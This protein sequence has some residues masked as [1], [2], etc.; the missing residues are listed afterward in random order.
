MNDGKMITGNEVKTAVKDEE[1]WRGEG[2]VWLTICILFRRYQG[3]W[4]NPV[5]LNPLGRALLSEAEQKAI[6]RHPVRAFHQSPFIFIQGL[7]YW[8]RWERKREREK[9]QVDLDSPFIWYLWAVKFF[10]AAKIAH[11]GHLDTADPV[12]IWLFMGQYVQKLDS[13][14]RLI[15]AQTNY[16]RWAKPFKSSGGNTK[17]ICILSSLTCLLISLPWLNWGNH[18]AVCLSL[19]FSADP[20]AWCEQ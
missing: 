17:H 9:T 19:Y 16:K 13:N 15:T 3:T 20:W 5:R 4:L 2:G 14:S 8:G 6:H 12:C 11:F 1:A 7:T 18:F 10:P